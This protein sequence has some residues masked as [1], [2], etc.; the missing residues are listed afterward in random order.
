MNTKAPFLT[1]KLSTRI[2]AL[3]VCAIVSGLVQAK[4]YEVTVAVPVSSAGLDL[5]RTAGALELYGRLTKAAYF[6]C[7]GGNRVDLKPLAP[8][9]FKRCNETALGNAVRSAN[10]PQL[11]KVYL[12]THTLQDAS[13]HGIDVSVLMAAK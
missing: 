7:R 2:G 12:E 3:A 8:A 10:Q 5:S 9:Q 11:T 4:D 6:V 13:T 1:K